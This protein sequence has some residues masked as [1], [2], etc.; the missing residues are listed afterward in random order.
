MA[1]NRNIVMNYFNGIDYDTLYPQT[2]YSNITDIASNTYTQSQIDNMISEIDSKATSASSL[3]SSLNTKIG[4][5]TVSIL[6]N[7][8][9]NMA[10]GSKKILLFTVPSSYIKKCF[11]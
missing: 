11:Y 6:G 2:L 3:A 7:G 4:S 8:T 9:Y 5:I 1:T 10:A